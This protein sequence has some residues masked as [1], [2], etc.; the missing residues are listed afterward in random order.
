M[1]WLSAVDVHR[2][3]CPCG[4]GLVLPNRAERRTAKQS[5]R[6]VQM[7]TEHKDDCPATDDVLLA[8]IRQWKQ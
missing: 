1:P 4:A 7:R 2:V 6:L 8:A 3:E 5:G